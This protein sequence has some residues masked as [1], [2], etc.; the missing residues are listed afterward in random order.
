MAVE[1]YYVYG[2]SL[3]WFLSFFC[4]SEKCCKWEGLHTIETNQCKWWSAWPQRNEPNRN[5]EDINRSIIIIEINIS[6]LSLTSNILYF[7]LELKCL[8]HWEKLTIRLK[9]IRQ[10]NIKLYFKWLKLSVGIRL[11]HDSSA[12][13][14]HE[15]SAIVCFYIFQL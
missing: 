3:E 12:F 9:T 1:G 14:K 13:C 5:E 2:L 10:L 11:L 7:F 4:V 6:H 15:I 8:E